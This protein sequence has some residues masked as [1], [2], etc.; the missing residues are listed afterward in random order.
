L[1]GEVLLAHSLRAFEQHDPV[2]SIVLVVP[3]DWVAPTEV[4]VDDLGC[5]R[6]ASIEIAGSSRAASV[7]AGLEAVVDRRGTAVLVHDAARPIVPADLIDRVLGPLSEGAD[8][9]VPVLE[10]ADT[11]KQIDASTGK[12]IAT[13]ARASL[14]RAQTPQACR[15][16]SLH[17]ALRG[18]DDTALALITDCSMAIENNGGTCVVVDG[19]LR[20]HKITTAADLAELEAV[21]SPPPLPADTVAV[22]AS[23]QVL[24]D[25]DPEDLE[26][27]DEE[28][29]A[30]ATESS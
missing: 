30:G 10:V 2:D 27:L 8:A 20:T 3:E 12:I 18:L 21:L 25:E 23:G 11:I 19:D 15:A 24:G 17:A 13:P 9:V 16:S 7:L 22:D 28:D 6:V 4:L 1:A 29:L 5:D 26:P 14:R